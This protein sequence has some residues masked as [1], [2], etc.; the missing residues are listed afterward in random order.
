VSVIVLIYIIIFQKLVSIYI[1]TDAILSASSTLIDL[2][3]SK[4]ACRYSDYIIPHPS[5]LSFSTTAT[6]RSSALV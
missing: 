6:F 4:L 3:S 1:T 2:T 5:M